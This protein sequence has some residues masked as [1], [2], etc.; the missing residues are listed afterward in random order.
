MSFKYTAIKN[1]QI[2]YPGDAYLC[3]QDV[4]L[5]LVCTVTSVSIDA[6]GN[7]KA[8]LMGS[9]D[10]VSSVLLGIYPF[11]FD[12]ALTESAVSQAAA[13]IM[14]LSEFTGAVAVTVAV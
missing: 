3:N 4:N 1:V 7:F 12:P 6:E 14:A 11:A 2:H 9:V 13:Q 8:M 5:E 10:D